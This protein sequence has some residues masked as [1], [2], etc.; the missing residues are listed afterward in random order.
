MFAIP[1]GDGRKLLGLGVQ[2]GHVLSTATALVNKLLL[3]AQGTLN[4]LFSLG[5]Y[6]GNLRK[7]KEFR[8]PEPLNLLTNDLLFSAIAVF[9]Y[10]SLLNYPKMAPK[11]SASIQFTILYSW[12]MLE[13]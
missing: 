1:W 8:Q 9:P 3:L 10:K 4:L 12:K 7:Y 2:K 11:I 5:N 13:N 6:K